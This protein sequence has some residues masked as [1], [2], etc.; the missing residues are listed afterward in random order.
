MPM[1]RL[2]IALPLMMLPLLA[3]AQAPA[4]TGGAVARSM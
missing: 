2:M 4:A 1:P 3:M